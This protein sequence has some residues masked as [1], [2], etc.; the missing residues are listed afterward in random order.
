MVL[1][2]LGVEKW[3]AAINTASTAATKLP[4]IADF[5]GDGQADIAVADASAVYVFHGTGGLMWQAPTTDVSCCVGISAFDFEGDGKFELIV[6]DRGEVF[7]YRGADGTMLFHAPR[8]NETAYEQPVVADIDND[9]KGELVV[10]LFGSSG[11]SSGIIAYADAGGTWVSAPRIWNEQAYHVTN[12][13]ENGA[14]PRAEAP[15]PHA[16]FIY[17]GTIAS[18]R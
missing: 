2:H 12:V 6:Q 14:I 15:I 10:T 13:F 9:G 16:P 7:I 3:H 11:S 8:P 5:D 17:R 1:D 4:T 18:C